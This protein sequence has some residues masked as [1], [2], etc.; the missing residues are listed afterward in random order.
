MNEMKKIINIGFVI[1]LMAFLQSCY[2]DNVEELYPDALPCD[3]SNVGYSET[4]TTIMENNCN[5]CHSSGFPQ[6][7]I[8]T[9]NYDDLKVI[10]D[11]GKL[12]GAVN[13]DEGYSPMPQNRPK[14]NDCD[15][16]QIRIWI[17]NGALDD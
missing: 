14:L 5:G 17:E 7:G 15:L 13:H 6:G 11:N 8:I 3:T 1:V 12:W 9:D 4:I 10:A 2:Y 16:S